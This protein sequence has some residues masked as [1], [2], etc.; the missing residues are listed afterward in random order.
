MVCEG[1][2]RQRRLYM[3]MRLRKGE[4]VM[5]VSLFDVRCY[6]IFSWILWAC[7]ECSIRA[8]RHFGFVVVSEKLA[9]L[10]R[11]GRNMNFDRYKS[12]SGESTPADGSTKTYTK[13]A[14]AGK[15]LLKKCTQNSCFTTK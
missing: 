5:L 11:F 13:S 7:N 9:R 1:V 12:L 15:V 14:F 3:E 4:A 8:L 2:T 6:Q 10:Q